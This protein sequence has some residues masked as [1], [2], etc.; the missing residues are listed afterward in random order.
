M[1]ASTPLLRGPHCPQLIPEELRLSDDGYCINIEDALTR[2]H[3][4]CMFLKASM[5]FLQKQLIHKVRNGYEDNVPRCCE[6]K[7][8]SSLLI[9][10]LNLGTTTRRYFVRVKNVE[11][12]DAAMRM[13]AR[14]PNKILSLHQ[15]LPMPKKPRKNRS[16]F[17]SLLKHGTFSNSS[18]TEKSTVSKSSHSIFNFFKKYAKE[19]PSD[20]ELLLNNKFST[21]I[22]VDYTKYLGDLPL[23]KLVD[24]QSSRSI[25][26]NRTSSL[27]TPSS[28]FIKPVSSD[29]GNSSILD[30]KFFIGKHDCQPHPSG[31]L[32]SK[33]ELGILRVIPSNPT[34]CF[35]STCSDTC[36]K[37]RNNCENVGTAL[38]SPAP[39]HRDS[40]REQPSKLSVCIDSDD[41]EE[42]TNYSIRPGSSKYSCNL[43]DEVK[44]NFS[45]EVLD[46]IMRR[47]LQH[48]DYNHNI[49]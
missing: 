7:N 18:I 48:F 26:A 41:E 11:Q 46:V 29:F 28:A 43:T 37:N 27:Y 32:L 45:P 35:Q 9:F 33:E 42:G 3:D 20:S 5:A 23:L 8:Y 44:S 47:I 22:A 25:I 17:F 6:S 39:I 21:T 14:T 13:E 2:P 30:S 24:H 34:E 19:T 40:A 16:N 15:L 12:Y 36:R 38:T 10:E 1:D 49:K 31:T 4:D